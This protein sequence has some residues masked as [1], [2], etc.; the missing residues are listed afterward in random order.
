MLISLAETDIR[1]ATL[2]NLMQFLDE[3][4]TK[5]IKSS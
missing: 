2:Q 5:A 3:M 1:L 4:Y